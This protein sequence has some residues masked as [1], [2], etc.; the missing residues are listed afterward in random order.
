MPSLPAFGPSSWPRVL[1]TLLLALAAALLCVWLQTPIPWMI[2]P[3]LATSA[4]SVLGAPTESW[5]PFRNTGQWVIGTALGLYFTPAVGALVA[6]L[7]WAIALGIAWALML[8][9][10]FGA[11]LRRLHAGHLAHLTPAQLF[12]TT[13]F[14]GAIGG[15]S[16]MTLIAER[17]GARTDL[18]ASAHSLR[19]LLVTL[20]IP[21]A[22]QFWGVSGLDTLT[23]GVRDVQ[24]V[25]LLVLAGLTLVGALFMQWLD[26]ANP[27]FMGA[28]VVT[29]VVTLAGVSLSAIPQPLL[30][31]AQLVIGVSLGVRFTPAFVHTAPRW[32]ASVAFASFFMMGICALFGW[33]L[34]Q[35]T[36]LHPAT[37]LLG[38]APGGIAEMA[39]TAKVL[40]LGVPVVT[41]FQVCRL[42]AVL[43]LA[44]PVYRWRYRRM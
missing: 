34:S 25:G 44:E 16:E 40:Q 31:A 7:W 36:G 43:V 19:V 23:L 18:V 22:L 10:G 6:S 1:Q 3:L 21:F 11:W 41:A 17:Q 42:V 12:S 28:L 37:L 33:V 15:A 38:T 27:W 9:L 32:L 5:A 35:A 14:A 13:Y 30:N 29:M 8:G 4:V 24:P 26:R 20:T 39:I 2:G